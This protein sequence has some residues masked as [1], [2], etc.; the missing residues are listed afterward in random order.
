[1]TEPRA[2]LFEDFSWPEVFRRLLA[3][4]ERGRRIP[5]N[6]RER[7]RTAPPR[8]PLVRRWFFHRRGQ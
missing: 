8:I 1:M 4:G 7:A 6:E 3:G 2:A 5:K